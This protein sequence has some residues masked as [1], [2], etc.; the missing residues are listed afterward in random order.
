MTN[1][2]VPHFSEPVLEDDSFTRPWTRY[3]FDMW[4]RV[5]GGRSHTLGGMSSAALSEVGN[6][7]TGEDTLQSHTI[8]TNSLINNGDSLEFNAF[9]LFAAN[10]NNKR[11]KV[12]LGTTTIFDTT[13]IAFNNLPWS[14]TGT[15]LR[16]SATSQLCNINI[17]TDTSLLV[18][19][20]NVTST[21]E[22]LT[23][24]LILKITGEA[25]NDNDII[26]KSLITKVFPRV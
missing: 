1:F 17:F 14:I 22:D 19:N 4:K 23:S 9:G 2:S 26:C 13:A 7:G 25:T 21:T 11:I 12:L 5:G 20:C 15:I 16:L 6:V 8:T 3:F 10:A 24:S 18:L